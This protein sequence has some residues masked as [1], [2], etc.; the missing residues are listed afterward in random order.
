[1]STSLPSSH[2]DLLSAPGTAALA[3]IGAD[4]TP[5]VTAIWYFLEDGKVKISLSSARQ[6]LKNLQQR[7]TATFFVIDPQNPMRTIE[8]RAG[9]ELAPDP[10][11]AFG[12]RV[13]AHYGNPFDMRDIDQPGDLRWVATLNP[14]RG[15]VNG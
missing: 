9:V 6:K 2:L 1:M 11:L 5:Q 7:P 4:G 13:V 12:D 10:D 8:I 15:N 14:T 3:T